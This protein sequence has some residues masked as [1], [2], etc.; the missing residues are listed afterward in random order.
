[1]ENI[2]FRHKGNAVFLLRQLLHHLHH[3][4]LLTV[5]F[6][7]HTYADFISNGKQLSQPRYLHPKCR[8]MEQENISGVVQRPLQTNKSPH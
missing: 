7:I 5:S 8:A 6:F 1:M 2:L 3:Q 4:D